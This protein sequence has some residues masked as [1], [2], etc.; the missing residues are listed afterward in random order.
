MSICHS[1]IRCLALEWLYHALVS[2]RS[3]L[4]IPDRLRLMHWRGM[5]LNSFSAMFIQLPCLGV[6]HSSRCSTIRRDHLRQEGRIDG[7]LGV[8][9]VTHQ[10]GLPGFLV[11][12]FHQPG[13]L[14]RCRW[15][16]TCCQ[17]ACSYFSTLFRPGNH[18]TGFLQQ[19]DGLLMHAHHGM[20][21]VQRSGGVNGQ[22]FL[23]GSPRPV[24]AGSPSTGSSGS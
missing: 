11:P 13:D 6:W 5:E 22:D 7:F 8:Q 4:I 9:V 14:V 18:P 21:R 12:V 16:V 2:S 19:L 10:R 15:T 3:Y 17:P 1:T 20:L 24:P 23:H